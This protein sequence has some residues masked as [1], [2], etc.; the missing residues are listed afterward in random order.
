MN[1]EIDN[2]SESSNDYWNRL[3]KE[4]IE[5]DGDNY[6]AVKAAITVAREYH[7]HLLLLETHSSIEKELMSLMFENR[8]KR[9]KD[10]IK[11]RENELIFLNKFDE[12]CGWI[13]K[14]LGG[15]PAVTVS[16][17]LGTLEQKI[18]ETDSNP[19]LV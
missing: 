14:D 3:R 13:S 18:K 6:R 4:K 7:H 2:Q 16:K 19:N 12:I 8:I 17:R 1:K 10:E 9:F 11:L 5:L 15:M